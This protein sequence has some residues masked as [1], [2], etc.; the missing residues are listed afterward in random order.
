MGT[1]Y[2]ERRAWEQV[3]EALGD[4]RVVL[5]NG[6]RQAGKSTL[7]RRIGQHTGARWYSL[8][9][10]V[11]RRAAAS[12]PHSFVRLDSLM[13]IDEVQRDPELLLSMKSLVDEHPTPGRFLL[14]GSARLL[15]LRSL[16]DTLVGRM[17]II[18]LWPLSQGE[19]D[20]VRENF[21]DDVFNQGPD[22]FHESPLTRDDYIARVI[23][24]G[25][26]DA[27]HRE[28][29]R[30]TAYLTNY[31]SDLINRD[32]T[33]L[34][35]IE[36]GPQLRALVQAVAARS[37]Q[38]LSVSRVASDVGLTSV[39][40][41]RYLSLLE[42]VFLMKRIP[43]WTRR[44]SGRSVGQA[45]VAM[46]DSG[47]ASALLRQTAS[48]LRQP[49]GPLGGLL[50]GFVAMEIARQIPWSTDRPG[51]SHYRTKDGVEVDLVL[52]DGMGRVVALEVKASSTAHDR[53]FAG[54]RHL[55]QRLG[56]DLVAGLLLYTGHHTL[57]FGPK[58]RAVPISTLWT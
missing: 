20:G 16:P 53:D 37:S 26:P 2:V 3:I 58:F 52:E 45:K 44:I 30:R 18:E 42:E 31:V 54:L 6:A 1:T 32:V 39:T 5:V 13:I 23:R 15:G 25:F 4:T 10:A 22:I 51:L 33:Q 34:S 47:I 57:P 29:R 46:V 14:T 56:N 48:R 12:D 36:R 28:H 11:T 49:G 8:D 35:A 21:V 43:A 24:G 41:E 9:D 50:E 7:V 38:P 17:E 27:I 55:E 19:I 40:T